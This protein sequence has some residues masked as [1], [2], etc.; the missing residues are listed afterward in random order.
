MENPIKKDRNYRKCFVDGCDSLAKSGFHKIPKNPE[1]RSKWMKILK[2]DSLNTNRRICR[3][4][5]KDS[6]FS[7]S[8]KMLSRTAVPSRNLP[9]NK[10]FEE[11]CVLSDLLGNVKQEIVETPILTSDPLMTVSETLFRS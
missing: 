6:D 9:K 1:I 2:V 4:H 10:E 3:R 5:F 7:E 11:I 8:N